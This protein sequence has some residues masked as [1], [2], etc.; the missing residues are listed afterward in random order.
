MK[1]N[2]NGEKIENSQQKY[3]VIGWNNRRKHI[4]KGE[5]DKEIKL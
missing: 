3:D 1:W 5:D 2:D 4:Q